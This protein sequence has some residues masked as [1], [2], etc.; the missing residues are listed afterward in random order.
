MFIITNLV[1]HIRS[2]KVGLHTYSE[3]Y[4]GPVVYAGGGGSDTTNTTTNELVPTGPYGPQIPFIGQL[5]N[6]AAQLYGQGPLQAFEGLNGNLTPQINPNLQ[7][8]QDSIGGLAGGNIDQNQA[9]QQYL[10]SLGQGIN[11]NQQFGESL[12][13]GIAGGLDAQLAA[14]SNALSTFGG[15][16]A[17]N[18]QGAF[19][20]VFGQQAPGATNVP[21]TQGGQT[22]VSGALGQQLAGGGGQNPFLDQLVQSAIQSQTNAF[23]RNV[24]PGIRG[25]AQA[26]GQPGGTRQGIAEGIAAGDLTQSIGNTVS[27]IY[28]GAFDTQ[29]AAQGQAVGNVLGAQQ[30]DQSAGIAGAGIDSQNFNNYITNLLTGTGQVGT[31]IGG[32]TGL[33]LNAIGNATGQAGNL[34]TSGNQLG[35]NQTFGALSQIPGFQ[36]SSLGQFGA[37]NAVG[38]QQYGFD[39]SAITAAENQFLFNQNAPAQALSQFQQF[40]SGPYGSTVGGAP[41]GTFDQFGNP[42]QYLPQGGG[43]PQPGG[44]Q[45]GKGGQGV[46][47]PVQN[48]AIPAPGGPN[49]PSPVS[50][51]PGPAPVIGPDQVEAK[52]IIVI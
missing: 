7:Q 24:L 42:G 50:P 19:N 6:Q 29:N 31:N 21:G 39:Q 20:T 52:P 36:A 28:G 27:N 32:G 51:P 16:Q 43:V 34:F 18:A 40:I 25:E 41:Q 1:L 8:G 26:A 10:Q 38:V 13:P 45:Q 5:F 4:D 12:T 46:N 22:D 48:P 47:V 11:P 37:Q 49:G 23:N 17:S 30:G 44:P 35:Q 14:G 33:G 2:G 3:W 15:E 9:I